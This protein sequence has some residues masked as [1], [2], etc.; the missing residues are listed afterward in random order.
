MNLPPTSQFWGG[1]Q[2]QR[3]YITTSYLLVDT[4][5]Q[6]PLVMIWCHHH[7][8]W[9]LMP[10]ILI[11]ISCSSWEANQNCI[12][13]TFLSDHVILLRII[14]HAFCLSV[15][16]VFCL[17]ADL[18]LYLSSSLFLLWMILPFQAILNDLVL[19]S[20]PDF[21]NASDLI[22][23]IC[24]W[25]SILTPIFISGPRLHTHVWKMT[26]THMLHINSSHLDNGYYT[27]SIKTFAEN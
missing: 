9:H 16:G 18:F 14:I 19:P 13:K 22:A 1:G 20:F 2:L 27:N 26:K 10:H 6:K 3:T 4:I 8:P 25:Y 21:L 7:M 23:S 15:W 24:I 12:Q 5:N 11:F 17:I